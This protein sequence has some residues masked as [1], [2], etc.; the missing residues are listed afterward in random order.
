MLCI[1]VRKGKLYRMQIFIYNT[2]QILRVLAS[3]NISKYLPKTKKLG[4]VRG[5]L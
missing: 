4:C 1:T 3:Y 5:E 2:P